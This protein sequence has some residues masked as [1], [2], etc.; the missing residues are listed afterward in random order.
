MSHVHDDDL[1]TAHTAKPDGYENK[2]QP[3]RVE[4]L[5]FF[6]GIFFFYPVAGAYMWAAEG[7][8][9]GTTA[10]LLLG[11][12]CAMV[13]GYLW[14]LG[15]RVDKRPEDDP[16]GEIHER[17]GQL[18][19][20]SPHSWAPFVLGVAAT[21]VFAGVALGRWIILLGVILGVIGLVMQLFEF[22][23]GIHAH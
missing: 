6:L 14:I 2:H 10:F 3:M 18:G 19:E 4:M 16:F 1:L 15:R 22:S 11:T 20:F 23:R 8:P 12:L 5:M 13:G 21:L 9:V 17:E 7:E